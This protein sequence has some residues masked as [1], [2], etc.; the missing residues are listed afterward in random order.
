MGAAAV[1][2]VAAGPWLLVAEETR[3]TLDEAAR[4]EVRA[5]AEAVVAGAVGGVRSQRG[6]EPRSRRLR[7]FGGIGVFAGAVTEEADGNDGTADDEEQD[8]DPEVVHGSMLQQELLNR[9]GDA[10][11]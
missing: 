6:A 9:P 4:R 8:K 5:R 2:A 1:G 10:K 7:A 11:A 3:P